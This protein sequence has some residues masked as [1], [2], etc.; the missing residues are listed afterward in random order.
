MTE[1]IERTDAAPDEAER[2]GC[3]VNGA[4]EEREGR[5]EPVFFD[6]LFRQKRKHG[7]YRVVDVPA[8]GA[9][10]ADTHAHLQLLSDPALALARAGMRDV[11]FLCTIVDVSE[12]GST[13]FDKLNDW[14][15]EG[16]LNI[17][18]LLTRRC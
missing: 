15:F 16:A 3:E 17:R 2:G 5:E 4:H 11:R 14:K 13:T 1:E 10:V 9:P 6:T 8:T 12:D 7:K 18:R